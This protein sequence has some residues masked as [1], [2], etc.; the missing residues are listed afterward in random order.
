MA[1]ITTEEARAIPH[2]TRHLR[3]LCQSPQPFARRLMQFRRLARHDAR[4]T[5]RDVYISL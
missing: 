5:G 1:L 3:Q 2:Y 4:T